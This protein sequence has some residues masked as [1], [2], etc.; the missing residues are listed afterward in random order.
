MGKQTER[1]RHVAPAKAPDNP[2]ASLDQALKEE[3]YPLLLSL[4]QAAAAS[5][6]HYQHL[7]QQVQAGYLQASKN[8]GRW[9]VVRRDLAAWVLGRQAH[10]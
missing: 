1:R 8:S 4:Q 2:V 5:G 6:H 9:R 7:W 10:A 3:G